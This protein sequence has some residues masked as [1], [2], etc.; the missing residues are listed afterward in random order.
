ML[1]ASAMTVVLDH[2]RQIS[3]IS[4]DRPPG[5]EEYVEEDD[6]YE[7]RAPSKNPDGLWWLPRR[8]S[9]FLQY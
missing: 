6:M 1:Q 5:N 2:E 8:L 7:V 4:P 9:P 3:K